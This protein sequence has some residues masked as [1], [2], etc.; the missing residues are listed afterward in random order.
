MWFPLYRLECSS[1]QKLIIKINVFLFANFIV[2]MMDAS[3]ASATLRISSDDTWQNME[4]VA[5]LNANDTNTSRVEAVR[6]DKLPI[7]PDPSRGNRYLMDFVAN[8]S[9]F[10][11]DHIDTQR[12]ISRM[13]LVW[14]GKSNYRKVGIVWLDYTNTSFELI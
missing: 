6:T 10:V 14:N 13:Q 11:S 1:V 3:L 5:N 7:F 8:R 4:T 12:E 9:L 2:V